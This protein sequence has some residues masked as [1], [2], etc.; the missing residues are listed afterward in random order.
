MTGMLSLRR[1]VIVAITVFPVTAF[2]VLLAGFLHDG[3]AVADAVRRP[4]TQYA[5]VGLTAMGVLWLL[6]S[7]V[8]SGDP[9][10]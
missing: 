4:T 9:V 2:V 1:T 6:R 7:I 3:A 5:I 10:E 8:G